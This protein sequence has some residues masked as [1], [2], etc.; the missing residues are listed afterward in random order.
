MFTMQDARDERWTDQRKFW[1]GYEDG[2]RLRGFRTEYDGVDG[3]AYDRGLEVGL[4]KARKSL[5]KPQWSDN[6]EN[7]HWGDDPAI[8]E[9]V[10]LD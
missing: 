6:L 1:E 7:A 10:G 9:T 8:G 2:L 4:S 3:Q 5:N